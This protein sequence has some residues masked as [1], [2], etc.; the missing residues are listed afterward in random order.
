MESLSGVYD[1]ICTRKIKVYGGIGRQAV[2][3]FTVVRDIVNINSVTSPTNIIQYI[4]KSEI[5]RKNIF[6]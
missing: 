2:D 3:L 6:H 4:A 5:M 1:L